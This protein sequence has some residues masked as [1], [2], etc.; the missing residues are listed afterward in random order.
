[1]KCV[2]EEGWLGEKCGKFGSLG[3]KLESYGV[4]RKFCTFA[5]ETAIN[6]E[7]W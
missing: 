5:T 2:C 4:G 3:F 7:I 6:G 1:M